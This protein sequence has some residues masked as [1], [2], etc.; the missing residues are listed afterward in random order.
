SAFT[1]RTTTGGDSPPLT[2]TSS[3]TAGTSPASSGR[4][5]VPPANTP[6]GTTRSSTS[7]SRTGP[8]R[9][10]TTGSSPGATS[11]PSATATARSPSAAGTDLLQR[12]HTDD[13]D[14]RISRTAVRPVLGGR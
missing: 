6:S 11:A 2:S 1:A 14:R 3:A 12:A 7:A 4:C 13:P 9:G 10:T 5:G 8:V